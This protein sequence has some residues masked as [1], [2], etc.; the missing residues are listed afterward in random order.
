MNLLFSLF[1]FIFSLSGQ[2]TYM[3]PQTSQLINCDTTN[4]QMESIQKRALIDTTLH[5]NNI[6]EIINYKNKN[7]SLFR[8]VIRF[9]KKIPEDIKEKLVYDNSILFHK[10]FYKFLI[11]C[12]KDVKENFNFL[13]LI[14]KD[15]G[16]FS[17]KQLLSLYNQF[18]EKFTKSDKGKSYLA[19][20]NGR[21]D[22]TGR[23]LFVSGNLSFVSSAGAQIP[24]QKL[25]D[26]NHQFYI[27]LFTASWCAPCRY[28]TNV[29]RNDLEKLN[30]NQ[31]KIFSISIDKSRSEWL[32][33]LKKENYTWNNYRAMKNWDSEIISYLKME[34]IPQFLLINEKGIIIAQRSGY[35][36]KE[37]I[38]RINR[39]HETY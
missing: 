35:G 12:N 8:Q 36:M 17:Q 39:S 19:I 34:G 14:I 18:P 7:D 27:I 5:F 33:Y 37:I 15:Y 11:E 9:N 24:L 28:Y 23:S 10:L 20:I 21:P 6:K 3:A 4:L 29:F 2:F 38:D 13:N 1:V 31:V 26:G 25:I 22:N 30:P 16:L 32:E